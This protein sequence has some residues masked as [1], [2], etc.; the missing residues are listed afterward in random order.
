[1]ATTVQILTTNYSGQT[2]TIT[3]SPCSGGT[4]NLGSQ[5]V[6]YNYVSDNYLGDYSLYFADFSQTCTFS[7]PCTTATP[8]PTVIVATA[9][10]TPAPTDT[11]LPAT[12][13]P[14]PTT[15]PTP[16]PVNN[17]MSSVNFYQ[18][19]EGKLRGFFTSNSDY[20]V[21]D[22]VIIQWYL[23]LQ[24]TTGTINIPDAGF[25]QSNLLTSNN[26]STSNFY[27]DPDI[28]YNDVIQSGT[29]LGTIEVVSPAS[30]TGLNNYTVSWESFGFNSGLPP[31]VTPTPTPL[32]ATSTPTSTP[33]PTDAPTSTPVSTDTPTPTPI[34]IQSYAYQIDSS[35]QYFDPYQACQEQT[36]NYT[37]YTA[38]P[39]LN[40]GNTLYSD[41]QLV[42]EYSPGI[43]NYF[44]IED[45]I[46]KYVIDV[47]PIFGINS[48]TNCIDVFAPTPI[49]SVTPTPIPATDTPTPT[50][51]PLFTSFNGKQFSGGTSFN[52]VCDDIE[53]NDVFYI[54]GSDLNAPNTYLYFDEQF[55]QPVPNNN[56]YKLIS[57]DGFNTTVIATVDETGGVTFV[58]DCTTYINEYNVV[59]YPV[60]GNTS[61]YDICQSN[62]GITGVYHVDLGA[63]LEVGQYLY[64]SHPENCIPASPNY[65]Y[66]LVTTTGGTETIH[67]VAVSGT[68]GTIISVMDCSL[69]DAPTPTP[70]PT[71]TTTPLPATETP[72]PATETPTPTPIPSFTYT[73]YLSEISGASAC[74][75]G[76]TTYGPYHQ[77]NVTGDT[78][79]MCSSTTFR[80]DELPTLDFG[81]F[82]MSDGTNSR[83]VQRTGGP[84]SVTAIPMGTCVS[85]P[86][87]TP[88]PVPATATPIPSVTPTPIPATETPI[89][90][91]TPTPIPATETPTP[92]PIPAT[93][94][95]TPTP[96]AA[97]PTP[98]ETTFSGFV[99]LVN[100][101][102]ACAGGE[103]GTVTVT[104]QGTSLCNLTQ[105]KG[106][107]STMFGNV[108]G[109]MTNNTTF[110][111][112]NGTDE[113]EFIRNG[114]AETGT[115]QTACTAC[116]AAPTA[117][118]IPATA[119]PTPTPLPATATPLP[120]T[121]TP[122]PATATP[123]PATATPIPATATPTPTPIPATATPTPTPEP[124]ISVY[125]FNSQ[126]TGYLACD[127]GTQISVSLNNPDFC[128]TTTFTSNYFTSLG[129]TTY[130]LA[131]GG[132]YLQIFHNGS[133]NQA[134]RSQSCQACNNTP[135]TATPIPATATP[136]P[137]TATPTPLPPT[138][139][140]C[141]APNQLLSTY[142][143]IYDLYG[144]YTDGSC[145]TYDAL[146]ETNSAGCGYETPTPTPVPATPTPTPTPEAVTSY[147]Y[148]LGSSYTTTGQACSNFGMD[149]YIDAFAATDLIYNVTQFFT[150]SGLTTPYV[151]E[152]ETHA[153]ALLDGFT[154][155]GSVYTGTI[156]STG[157]VTNKSVCQ[158][159]N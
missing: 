61:Y 35:G 15:T 1:M 105:I 126:P 127:G 107:S 152:S 76:D 60:S 32:P 47:Q 124:V 19:A 26:T 56:L 42:S 79:D 93:E 145:G 59:A 98:F 118:P 104:V 128:S 157:L 112:S 139:T 49:P 34:P 53:T 99:S 134:T 6:P 117:T 97:T 95:P 138:A 90:S 96:L 102:T 13:T 77:F 33:A 129:T 68:T 123:L 30:G 103:Y 70:T 37:V 80:L 89:P 3:F 44:I 72:I 108:Y 153:F 125:F 156:S 151:G 84:S 83:E 7:I 140:P 54:N 50:P 88:T 69:I 55:T 120:A 130:W 23:T 131:Y 159:Q 137:A 113:R 149:F 31:D 65:V 115:A 29:T 142:C 10:P 67:I 14:T 114:S 48:I 155:T 40:V 148:Q 106:L 51:T 144:R 101:P 110:W 132:S 39:T 2:A 91:V 24:T 9:T 75:G 21:T 100:G 45:A 94:T 150:D 119:T 22:D 43:G 38:Y 17:I 5:V 116:P 8:T 133:S 154:P 11:P 109:D 46:N 58:Y 74:V 64:N 36:V 92:T 87:P 73:V 20:N 63:P 122:V 111:V 158:E 66:K 141:P 18:T 41:S 62:D 28:N 25:F 71:S 143:D 81:I 52:C 136:L 135:A 85:C 146:I 82:Y 57:T 147:K 78:A 16:L 27:T 121:A 86:T 12:E 4:I